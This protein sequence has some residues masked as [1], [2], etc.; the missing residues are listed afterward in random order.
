MPELNQTVVLREIVLSNIDTDGSLT[1]SQEGVALVGDSASPGANKVYGT[2][3]DGAKGWQD[4]GNAYT[5]VAIA[6]AVFSSSYGIIY[7]EFYGAVGDGSTDDATDLAEFFTTLS[8]GANKLI[9]WMRRSVFMT[10]IKQTIS[11]TPIIL[12]YGTIKRTLA[13]TIDTIVEMSL[14]TGGIT[15]IRLNV[16]GN[17]DNA[18][19]CIGTLINSGA[20]NTKAKHELSAKN[21][22]TG[23]KLMG[24]VEKVNINYWV[25]NHTIGVNV[26]NDGSSATVDEANLMIEGSDCDTFFLADGT[27][28]MSGQVTFSCEQG[29]SSTLFAIDQQN[30]YWSYKGEIRGVKNGVKITTTSSYAASFDLIL[31]GKGALSV[32]QALLC[33]SATCILKGNLTLAEWNE[34]VWIKKCA[35]GSSLQINKRDSGSTGTGLRVGDFANGGQVASF[36]LHPSQLFGSTNALHLDYST[37]NTFHVENI[38]EGGI[39]ISANSGGNTIILSKGLRTKTITNSRTQKDN[40]ILFKGLYTNSELE[41]ITALFNGVRVEG[42]ANQP[43]YG[44]IYYNE[45]DAAW[46]ST[47]GLTYNTTTNTWS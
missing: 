43:S 30:G 26:H 36:T 34:G 32:L 18:N 25:S 5:D 9:G 37:N 10:S 29:E 1:S 45:S 21:T 7:P 39:T 12:G 27:E 42:I 38:W 3:E 28:K 22:T 41:S 13:S 16:D 2:D 14:G 44:Q 24:N 23:H 33:E 40:I 46:H 19:T 15:E 4:N 11:N 31:I 8:S 35:G 17:A 6:Q 20:N 47:S